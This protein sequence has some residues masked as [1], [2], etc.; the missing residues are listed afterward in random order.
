MP[1]LT[2][3]NIVRFGGHA[4]LRAVDRFSA[5]A[6]LD[7]RD[8]ALVRR[9]VGTELRRRATLRAIVSRYAR[10]KPNAD[11]QAHLRLGVV[12]LLMMDNVPPHAA[13]SETVRAA[14]DTVGLA[15]GRYV[16]GVLREIQRHAKHG[17]VGEARQDL[18]GRPW[19]FDQPV[20][21]DPHEH[22]FLW[23]EDALSV[24]SSLV[25][26]WAA[27]LGQER[28]M[29]LAYQ[30]MDEAPL[31]LRVVRG[32]VEELRAELLQSE[33]ETT[34]GY[35]P[36]HLHAPL[37][38][39]G[40]VTRSAAFAEGRITIQGDTAAAAVRLLNPQPNESIMELCAAPGGK[41]MG[42][43][44]SGA[45]VTSLDINAE[46]LAKAH[47]SLARL[48]PQGRVRLAAMD[49]TSALAPGVMF[50]GAFVD[51]PCSNTGVL[52]QRP[53]ARWR[54]GPS[55]TK[56]LCAIQARLLAEC[57]ARVRPGGRMVYSTCS[58][59]PEENGQQVRRFLAEH[60]EWSAGPAHEFL[61]ITDSQ[62]PERPAPID[63][64][65]AAVLLRS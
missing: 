21:R 37:A 32:D 18:V 55:S 57:A 58:I 35:G 28:A 61:P 42:L 20:F 4:P 22:P 13:V 39:V 53:A 27:R 52:A 43:A 63:G 62:D 65:F 30:A 45:T 2:A 24:P 16:N 31:G 41:T 23:A 49:G 19:F 6:G 11:I 51:A 56:E 12:Q 36:G 25:K 54:F 3:W 46:R 59:E 5:Q 15:R 64:G 29:E 44:A 26:R 33:I 1:R 47:G 50:D 60:P 14:A 48:A 34:L 40:E 8:R 10:G 38:K 7:D 9:M 17:Q